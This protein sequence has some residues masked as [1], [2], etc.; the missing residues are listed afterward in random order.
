MRLGT[1]IGRITL[2]HQEPVY[3]GGR[4]LI[5]QPWTREQFAIEPTRPARSGTP[6]D[7]GDFRSAG[8]K[9]P[10]TRG[11]ARSDGVCAGVRLAKGSSVVVYDELGAGQGSTIGFIEGAEAAQPFTGDA[12]VDAYCA[13]ILD[14]LNYVGGV[15]PPREDAPNAG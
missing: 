9:S 2:T 12:P 15:T 13:C 10:L 7:R 8:S 14:Q 5:V 1:V 3:S 6:L 4:L 11:V